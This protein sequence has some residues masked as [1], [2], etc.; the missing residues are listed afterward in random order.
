MERRHGLLAPQSAAQRNEK[1]TRGT[2]SALTDQEPLFR[3]L[4]PAGC[5]VALRVGFLAPEDEFN[6]FPSAWTRHYTIQAFG[7]RDPL[8]RWAATANGAT[9]WSAVHLPDE[10]G[11][12]ADYR[13]H[14]L[15]FGCVIGLPARTARSRKRSFGL[16]ARSDR[17]MTNHEIA[18]LRA[19]I[20][21]LHA[22]NRDAL[23]PSQAEVLRMLSEGVRYKEIAH[24]LGITEGAVKARF[25][26]ACDRLGAR[27][28][29]QA[30][31]IAQ[32][33]GL[34]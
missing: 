33:R 12:L 18:T 10:A 13:R 3:D 31:N 22:P 4:A 24:R 34:L 29:V 25:K 30:A 6:L 2:L 23:T 28:A 19:T 21:E 11:V 16:F 27:T 7:L 9:R 32:R 8:I 17:E 20:A 26:A 1:M 5:Y 14:G 15:R